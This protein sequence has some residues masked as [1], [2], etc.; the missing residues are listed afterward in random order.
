M[1]PTQHNETTYTYI[2][3]INRA[4]SENSGSE[5]CNEQ[6]QEDRPNCV[7]IMKKLFF[8]LLLG[9][10]VAV[11]W[12]IIIHTL[13]WIALRGN[14]PFDSSAQLMMIGGTSGGAMQKPI[15]TLTSSRRVGP[16]LEQMFHSQLY[17]SSLESTSPSNANLQVSSLRE[18]AGA[19]QYKRRRRRESGNGTQ[20]A[21]EGGGEGRAANA[22]TTQFNNGTT[23]ANYGPIGGEER[24][25]PTNRMMR[26]RQ[27][28]NT[29][30]DQ[31]GEG[32]DDSSQPIASVLDH[33]S[34]GRGPTSVRSDD[35][36]EEE[37]Q[38]QASKLESQGQP[39]KVA[40][41]IELQGQPRAATRRQQQ[42]QRPADQ[43]KRV[44]Q[45]GSIAANTFAPNSVGLSQDELPTIATTVP[46]VGELEPSG[47]PMELGPA[48][49]SPAQPQIVD[50]PLPPAAHPHL[51]YR[52][53][54]FTSWF[55]SIWN[56]L[57]MP[58]FTLI[59]S[60]CFRNEDS[61]TKKLLV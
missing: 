4:P 27:L 54:F 15:A 44:I 26:R 5:Q 55:V 32:D 45:L 21:K 47:D 42:Q 7:Q 1:F 20:W 13:K 9:T 41:S 48:E 2:K 40:A 53:P 3:I 58:V 16:A 6:D 12:V 52:A 11:C 50:A 24:R 34:L 56:I 43:K 25:R 60:C 17:S 37:E 19:Q 28:P 46:G 33:A 10:I 18:E 51:V 61:S 30:A 36:N 14:E 29:E 22:L 49:Q 23:R 35:N 57:F 8:S 31:S 59:S 38:Q 39:P